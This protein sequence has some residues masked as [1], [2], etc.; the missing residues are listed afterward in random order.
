MVRHRIKNQHDEGSD[1][2][3]AA[4]MGTDIVVQLTEGPDQARILM[5]SDEAEE[6]AAELTKAARKV[7]TNKVTEK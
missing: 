4:W 5:T 7:R 6:M 2:A 3:V 1:W